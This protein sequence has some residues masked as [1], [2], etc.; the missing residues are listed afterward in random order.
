M[1]CS[2]SK[3]AR[4]VEHDA[5]TAHARFAVEITTTVAAATHG[6]VHALLRLHHVGAAVAQ[7]AWRRAVHDRSLNGVGAAVAHPRLPSCQQ[8]SQAA[9]SASEG[10][11]SGTSVCMHGSKRKCES[12]G[13]TRMVIG[14]GCRSFLVGCACCRGI[15]LF[16]ERQCGMRVGIQVRGDEER[17]V[18]HAACARVVRLVACVCASGKRRVVR[19]SNAVMPASRSSQSSSEDLPAC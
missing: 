5:A 3:K 9:H 1:R 8:S 11:Q 18:R 16:A 15:M 6:N 4:A 13:S 7:P 14:K 10:V 19:A 12:S 17:R 2:L